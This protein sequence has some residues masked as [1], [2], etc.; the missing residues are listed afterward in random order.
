MDSPY[1]KIAP[2]FLGG[3]AVVVG[4]VEA[5]LVPLSFMGA[6]VAGVVVGAGVGAGVAGVVVVA[7]AGV[8]GAGVVVVGG[9][10]GPSGPSIEGRHIGR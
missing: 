7:G 6:V 5:G 1:S 2:P 4:A 3:G 9:L 8:V 10:M